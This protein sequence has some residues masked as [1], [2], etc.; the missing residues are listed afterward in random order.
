M[1]FSVFVVCWGAVAQYIR[2]WTCAQWAWVHF[3]L[4]P[5][6]VILIGVGRKG[7]W[8]E[9]FPCTSKVIPWYARPSPWATESMTLNSD[10]FLAFLSCI[11]FWGGVDCLHFSANDWLAAHL[12]FSVTYYM[13]RVCWMLHT[14]WQTCS[15]C[16]LPLLLWCCWFSVTNLNEPPGA[17]AT[18]AIMWVWS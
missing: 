16:L 5:V 4:V 9:L 12:Q 8:P 3:P 6:W 13:L 7:I 1:V 14:W 2:R 11:F 17:L 18:S 10:V 15:P